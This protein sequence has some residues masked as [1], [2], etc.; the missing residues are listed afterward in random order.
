MNEPDKKLPESPGYETRD[1][2]VRSIFAVGLVSLALLIIALIVLGQIFILSK[3]KAIEDQVLKPVSSPLRELRSHE[4]EVLNSY[5]VLDPQ[6]G[7]YQIPIQQ[8]IQILANHAYE[9]RQ[10]QGNPKA[11]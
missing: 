3:E 7:V 11:P 5:K 8:A 1:L 10:P 6:K 2:N 9:N 4:D